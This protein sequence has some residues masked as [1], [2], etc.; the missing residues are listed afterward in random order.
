MLFCL[1]SAG[2]TWHDLDAVAVATLPVR[3]WAR[4]SWG[5]ASTSPFSPVAGA[6]Y[7]ANELGGLARDLSNLRILRH[8][9]GTSSC[10]FLNF[11]HHL[12]HA[13][14]S[15]YLSPFDR[16]L[17]LTLDEEGD[18]QAGMLALGEG[19][20]LRPLQ[21]ISFPHSLGWVY[22]RITELLGFI[23]QKEEHKTQWLSMEGEPVFKQVFLDMLRGKNNPLPCLDSSFVHRGVTGHLAFSGK[24]YRHLGIPEGDASL[25]DKS[26]GDAQDHPNDFQY[27]GGPPRP[28]YD[29]TGYTLALQMG[30]KFDRILDGFEG[31]FQKIDGLARPPAGKVGPAENAAGYLLSHQVNDS[32]AGTTRLLAAGEEVYW[33]KQEFTAN[34]KTYPVGTIY[35]PARATTAPLLAKLAAEVGLSF[36]ATTAKPHG[37]A[38]KLRPVRVGL[39]DRYGGSQDSGHI[40]WLFEQAFPTPYE[41]VYAPALD[42]GD[43][44][45]KYDVLI[46]PGGAI[47]GA[48][49]RGGRGGGPDA[50]GGGRFGGSEAN[51]PDEYKNQVGNITAVTTE[52]QLRRFVEEGGTVLAIGSSTS[53]GYYLGLPLSNALTEA[54]PDGVPRRLAGDKFYVPGAIRE[55]VF[56]HLLAQLRI[57]GVFTVIP[58]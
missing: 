1:D 41:R 58:G 43:L 9:N 54:G 3:G 55:L 8:K 17:I 46:F 34:G 29:I 40:R 19:T 5:A 22:S 25:G 7:E 38:L 16:A 51:I 24:F 39:W 23:P 44:K 56:L 33:L 57:V 37:E 35:I 10:R 4:R 30:V 11:E 20:R 52:P 48:G 13:G 32:F 28:P 45:S 53:F 21:T 26:L 27:P 12:C 14:S 50:P 47:P 42:A 2:L 49:G 36:D 31:P 6:Y 18:G 15:F